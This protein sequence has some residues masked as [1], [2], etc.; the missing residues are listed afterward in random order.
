LVLKNVTLLNHSIL[1][2]KDFKKALKYCHDI[3]EDDTIF[4]GFYMYL[5]AKLWT[6]DTRS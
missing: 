5:K 3:D 6:G 1:P 4:V 2:K